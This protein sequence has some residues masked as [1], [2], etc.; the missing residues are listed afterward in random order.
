MVSATFVSAVDSSSNG[1]FF[2]LKSGLLGTPLFSCSQLI[3]WPPNANA[4][5]S[6][7]D[8]LSIVAYKPKPGNCVPL[9]TPPEAGMTFANFVALD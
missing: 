5:E 3:S 6:T 4:L 2:V 7:A 1:V 8:R 9:N